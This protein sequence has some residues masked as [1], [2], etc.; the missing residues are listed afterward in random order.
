V[1]NPVNASST[2][3]CAGERMTR[4]ISAGDLGVSGTGHRF[5]AR[6]S[7]SDAFGKRTLPSLDEEK[8]VTRR[9]GLAHYWRGHKMLCA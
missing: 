1:P 2:T 6:A 9:N 5:E 7:A 3:L 4:H 8:Y